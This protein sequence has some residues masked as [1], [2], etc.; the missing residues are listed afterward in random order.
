MEKENR[1][2][3]GHTLRKEL[4]GYAD[5]AVKVRRRLIPGIW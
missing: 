3:I 4:P 1:P 5:Y 2:G